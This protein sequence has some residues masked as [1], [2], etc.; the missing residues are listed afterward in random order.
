MLA[1]S[2]FREM[3]LAEAEHHIEQGA[4]YIDLRPI[5][6]YLDVHVPGSL[7]LLYEKGPGMAAR[8]RDCLPLGLPLILLND[9]RTDDLH[10]AASLRGKGFNVV[11]RVED[12]LGAW[13][14][15]HGAPA[16]IDIAATTDSPEGTLLDVG[17]SGAPKV[18]T[19]RHCPIENLW[20]N[21]DE[22]AGVDHLVIIAGRGVRAALAVGILERAG[23]QHI[24]Y[25]KR[26]R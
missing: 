20:E 10:A 1:T 24:S 5:N 2:P 11:G 19:A 18:E 14:Q 13:A 23:A 16:S 22:F 15:K 25:W 21:V 7:A 6:D 4:A 8:A 17:D 3:R 26:P 9:G 12:G